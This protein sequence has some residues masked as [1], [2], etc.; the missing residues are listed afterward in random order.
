MKKIFSMFVAAAAGFLAYAAEA[1]TYS[2]SFDNGP[3]HA[4][5][6]F[7]QVPDIIPIGSA[8]PTAHFTSSGS[9]YSIQSANALGFTPVGFS[10][11]CLYPDSVY[12]SDVL[13]SFNKSLASLSILYSPEEY[14][15]DTSCTMEVSAYSGNTLVGTNTATVAVPGTWPTGTLGYTNTMRAFDH[16]VIHYLW[17]P[18][19]GGDWGPVFMADNLVVTLATPMPTNLDI[20]K[21]PNNQV[22]ITWPSGW[23]A[24][25]VQ[26]N[27][28][29]AN[30]NGWISV[31]NTAV[32]ADPVY[33]VVL[34]M[35]QDG[36]FYRLSL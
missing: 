24:L 21:L 6:P 36:M 27:S 17:P 4:A 33:N 11:Y 16:V 13:I 35:T 18:P 31:T 30:T 10:G 19:T 32:L 14:A 34:P 7:D 1:Q 23:G 12:A 2:F 15:T 20:V 5:T 9:T 28:N 3:L 22:M 25:R 26:S 8:Y 29:L